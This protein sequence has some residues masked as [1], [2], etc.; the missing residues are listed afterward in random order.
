MLHLLTI[1]YYYFQAN[2]SFNAQILSAQKF[3]FFITISYTFLMQR[4]T[5][6]LTVMFPCDKSFIHSMMEFIFQVAHNPDKF[7]SIEI[8]LNAISIFQPPKNHKFFVF[9]EKRKKYLWIGNIV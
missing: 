7:P 2:Y 5:S 8:N 3:F 1:S 4:L 6:I 9:W